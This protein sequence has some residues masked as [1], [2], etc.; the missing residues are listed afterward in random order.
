M[1]F[2]IRNMTEVYVFTTFL[3]VPICF[4]QIIHMNGRK[5][6]NYGIV[7]FFCILTVSIMFVDYAGLMSTKPHDPVPEFY[8]LS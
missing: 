2:R 1:P 7:L 3:F 6:V 5:K 4:L 8:R